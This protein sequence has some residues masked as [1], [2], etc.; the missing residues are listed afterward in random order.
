M[1]ALVMTKTIPFLYLVALAFATAHANVHLTPTHT[2]ALPPGRYNVISLEFVPATIWS[3]GGQSHVML[4]TEVEAW[5]PNSTGTSFFKIYNPFP[6]GVRLNRLSQAT[7][8]PANQIVYYTGGNFD[9]RLYAY[10]LAAG[11]VFSEDA[12]SD[13]P[14]YPNGLAVRHGTNDV[15]VSFAG[16]S[17]ATGYTPSLYRYT[18][19]AGDQN[20]VA[21]G[22]T[23]PG[24][25]SSQVGALRIGPD[26]RLNVLDAGQQKILRYDPV[27]LAYVD[28]ISLVSTAVDGNAFAISSTGYIF[29]AD[30]NSTSGVIYNYATG[31]YVGTFSA[32]LHPSTALRGRLAMTAD[33][34]GNVYVSNELISS[35]LAV[36]STA[37]IPEPAH[38][39]LAA[40]LLAGLTFLQRRRQRA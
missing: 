6:M 21:F 22:Y 36:Y 1:P 33:D 23:G 10:S 9:V 29:T 16:G 25:V 40:G 14:D 24:A 32:P 19:G 18:A 34:L 15:F 31:A 13:L 5:M 11:S 8:D 17:E 7:Y 35:H 30:L 20:G 27:T 37:A 39:A 12:L 26:G 3:P 2:T 38:Y 28:A 4:T